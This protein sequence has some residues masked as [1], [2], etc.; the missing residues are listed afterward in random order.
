MKRFRQL[1]N[2]K[3]PLLTAEYWPPRGKDLSTINR[4]ANLYR[5]VVD[6]VNVVDNPSSNVRMNSLVCCHLLQ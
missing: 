2:S 3:K 4:A 5:E 1:L 6:A